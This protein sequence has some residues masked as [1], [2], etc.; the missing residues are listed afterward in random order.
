MYITRLQAIDIAIS[1]IRQLSDTEDN[2]Q[3]I[4]RLENIRHD[5][6]AIKWTC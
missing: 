5:C 1:A 3:A 4:E 2:R 6:K